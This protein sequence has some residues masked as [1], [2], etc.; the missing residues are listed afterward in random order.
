MYTII[1]T[2]INFSAGNGTVTGASHPR[3]RLTGLEQHAGETAVAPLVV[4]RPQ[5]RAGLIEEMRQ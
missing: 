5:V 3:G 4:H 1:A 2:C